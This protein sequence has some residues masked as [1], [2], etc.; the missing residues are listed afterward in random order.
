M[1]RE[2]RDTCPPNPEANAIA[3]PHRQTD[4]VKRKSAPNANRK[5]VRNHEE[6][7]PLPVYHVKQG[8]PRLRGIRKRPW[9]KYA[10]EIRD[11]A[12]QG[13][14]W[15]GTYDTAEQAARA[16]D[17]AARRIRGPKARTNFPLLPTSAA[18]ADEVA[19]RFA[20]KKPASAAG[21]STAGPSS[22]SSASS[23]S[24][25][26]REESPVRILT[27]APPAASQLELTL[28]RLQA[29]DLNFPPPAEI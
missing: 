16:Y 6:A 7:P 26:E 14:V 11:P 18:A 28:G 25:P 27:E 17:A 5:S 4:V 9:G 10:A 21:S 1:A 20:H 19:L 24:A 22:S 3:R 2:A 12:R 15:L 23:S 8:L 29:L 13:R